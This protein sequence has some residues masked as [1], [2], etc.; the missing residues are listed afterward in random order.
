MAHVDPS[1]LA[2]MRRTYDGVA[3]D[4]ATVAAS[5]LTQFRGWLADAVV[6]QVPEPNA[7]TLATV[8]ADGRP[9]S[10]TVLCKAVDER[11]LVF[12]ANHR[13][14]K[15]QA[16][17]ADPRAALTFPWLPI[18]R[19]IC[20]TGDVEQAT[21]A[22]TEAYARSRPRGSQIGAWVSHQSAVI[23]S[24]DQ[25]DARREELERRFAG[26]D[27]PVPDFWGGFR[28]LPLTVEFWSGHPDR[29]HDRVRYKRTDG[30]PGD[31]GDGRWV[32]ERL[33]P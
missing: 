20:I 22:E 30:R 2:A 32:I 26:S 11:G 7:M 21:R 3:L 6:A 31:A 18:Q 29:L 10:R 25:L 4:P 1:D 24:R 9:S 28:V 16:L 12:Y 27:V 17:K 8:D 19:Q 23:A 5:W 13:S 15:G 14:R 33:A